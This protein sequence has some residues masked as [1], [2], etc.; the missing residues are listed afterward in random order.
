[1]IS[2][3]IN[4]FHVLELRIE[5]YECVSVLRSFNPHNGQL[6]VGLIAQLVLSQRSGF[7]S[8]SSLNLYETAKNM[9]TFTDASQLFG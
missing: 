4:K 7:K 1:M 9:Y 3:E 8:R 2:N 6:S 5:N